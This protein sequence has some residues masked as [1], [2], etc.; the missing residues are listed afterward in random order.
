MKARVII[1]FS[2]IMFLAILWSS[3]A[4]SQQAGNINL[5]SYYA[6]YIDELASHCKN[7][8]SRHNS[9]SENIR[10]AAALY[11]LKADFFKSHLLSRP[12]NKGW[13]PFPCRWEVCLCWIY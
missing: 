12:D 3:Q 7:K 9:K 4:T 5:K 13:E 6:A 10:Q 1:I 8:A 11:C 2:V